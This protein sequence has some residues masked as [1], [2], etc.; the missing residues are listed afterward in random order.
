MIKWHEISYVLFDLD[1]VIVNS[2]HL[3]YEA[4]RGAFM[5]QGL[6]LSLESYNEKLRSKGRMEGLNGLLSDEHQGLAAAISVDKD[7]IFLQ[8][9][10]KE[11]LQVYNDAIK[12]I[13]HCKCKEIPIAI[14]TASKMGSKVLG[15]LGIQAL[16]DIIITSQDVVHNKP[17]PEIYLKCIEGLGGAP[18]K[19]MVIEDSEAG[20]IAALEADMNVTYI[21]R[22][23]ALPIQ[24]TYLKH[25]HVFVCDDLYQ[26]VKRLQ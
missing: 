21:K 5:A 22:H 18:E 14:G 13:E 16:F 4:Y 24:T 12:L 15:K 19:A 26:V 1:G 25:D 17:D 7:K 23:N 11:T 6:S 3:H 9:L 8:L 2:E 20:I 10:E